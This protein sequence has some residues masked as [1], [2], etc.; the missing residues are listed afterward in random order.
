MVKHKSI[1]T[2]LGLVAKE[3]MELE[4]LDITIAFLHGDLE[5]R[6][7]M[8]HPRTSEVKGKYH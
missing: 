2:V 5:E 1:G 4:K 3:N 8:H 6:K 7:Y